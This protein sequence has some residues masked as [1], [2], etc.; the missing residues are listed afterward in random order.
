MPELRARVLNQKLDPKQL[1]SMD[2]CEYSKVGKPPAA[3]A[4]PV[5]QPQRCVAAATT[6]APAVVAAP[7]A[8]AEP[9]AAADPATTSE[10][11]QGAGAQ[12]A[13]GSGSSGSG[14][15]QEGA[16]APSVASNGSAQEEAV[17]STKAE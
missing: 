14:S 15:A 3:T 11:V 6:A 1:V 10:P 2:T 7:A 13:S 5:Q 4:P 16:G 9:A 12:E 17:P 8:A